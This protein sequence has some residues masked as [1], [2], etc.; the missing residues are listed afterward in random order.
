MSAVD[1]VTLSYMHMLVLAIYIMPRI[2]IKWLQFGSFLSFAV[3]FL[4]MA[5]VFDTLLPSHP[6]VARTLS[7]NESLEI[8]THITSIVV[9]MKAVIYLYLYDQT[10][11][12]LCLHVR[13]FSPCTASCSSRC[14]RDVTSRSFRSQHWCSTRRIGPLST[15]SPQVKDANPNQIGAVISSSTSFY[16]YILIV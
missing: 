11:C 9:K 2:G 4:V 1:L 16:L 6:E 10:L 13:L 12:F 8:R 15:A 7:F 3:M 14:K 5:C